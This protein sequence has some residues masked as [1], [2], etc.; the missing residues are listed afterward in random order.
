MK[1]LL[2]F[3]ILIGLLLAACAAKPAKT[4]TLAPVVPT[5]ADIATLVPLGT[6]EA[7]YGEVARALMRD[8]ANIG[9]RA[10]GT[11]GESQAAQYVAAVF[12]SVGYSPETQT[13]TAAD[14]NGKSITSANIIAVKKGESPREIIVG[15]H[16]DSTDK[17]PGADEA[18]GVAAMLDVARLL[19]SQ[20]TP[21]TIRFV[22]FGATDSG[23]LGSYAMVNQMSMEQL[24]NIVAMVDLDKLTAGDFAYAYGDEGQQSVVRDWVLEWASGNGLELQTVMNV[25]LSDPKT[26]KGAS[27]YYAFQAIG[28][29][30]VFFQ[31]ADWT[32]GEK[33]GVTQVDPRYGDNGVISGTKFDTL[34]YLDTNFP[35]RVDKHLDLYISALYHFLTEY[36]A[37]LQ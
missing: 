13:F 6:P 30:Y 11:A 19:V 33:N 35:G 10:A 4:A 18:S 24:Q 5:R 2:P 31:A 9:P 21:Y 28:I 32:L 7:K 12:Q 1:K 23:L 34:D 20:N 8:F 3:F 17:G 27:D 37:P 25:N 22:A 14:N 26:G 29:P 36:Q 16:Y 15:S